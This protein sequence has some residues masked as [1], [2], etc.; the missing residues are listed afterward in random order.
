MDIKNIIIFLVVFLLIMWLQHNDDLKT[1]KV[2]TELYDKIKIPLVSSLLVVLIKDINY[3]ECL[4]VFQSVII[5]RQPEMRIL[6]EI[7]NN[8]VLNDIFIGPPDF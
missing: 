3:E 6:S 1:G 2:R 7:P 8:D 5:V 4:N